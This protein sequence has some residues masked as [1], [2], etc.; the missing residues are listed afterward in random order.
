MGGGKGVRSGPPV[1]QTSVACWACWAVACCSGLLSV[2]LV[3]GTS[4]AS[5][6]GCHF[7]SRDGI[8]NKYIK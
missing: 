5:L 8:V 6:R 1:Q 7:V 3:P 4:A 2:S